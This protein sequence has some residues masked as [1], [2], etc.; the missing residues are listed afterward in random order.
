[1][2]YLTLLGKLCKV[3]KEWNSMHTI[4][5]SFVIEVLR[6]HFRSVYRNIEAFG[7]A[8]S[9]TIGSSFSGIDNLVPETTI[10]YRI[11]GETA[12]RNI[13]DSHIVRK[14]KTD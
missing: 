13:I 2:H 3:P 1:M 10:I 4:C 5:F 9:I 8:I 11:R 6:L 7:R 12:P 14:R